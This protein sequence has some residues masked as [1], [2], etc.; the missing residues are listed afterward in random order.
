MHFDYLGDV[1]IVIISLSS[2]LVL[3]TLTA[4][5][6]FVVSSMRKNK[7]LKAGFGISS[8]IAVT[9]TIS[10]LVYIFIIL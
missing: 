10:F 3:M 5:A 9:A 7:E 4:V 1:V 2:F 6:G 8:V